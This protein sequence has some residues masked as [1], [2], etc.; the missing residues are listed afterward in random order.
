MQTH[1][2]LS[3]HT[4]LTIRSVSNPKLTDLN[5]WL[6]LM[7]EQIS[8]HGLQSLG[9][10]G[11]SFSGFGGYTAVHCL[12]ESHISIHT[13]PE[14]GLCTCDVFLSNFEKDND[15]VVREITG[16][17]LSYFESGSYDL[18]EIKR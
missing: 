5:A 18:N 15:Q 6:K 11:H 14:F 13:W 9:H 7:E 1:Y 4:L 12:T 10:I 2:Q 8:R 16:S 17:I 3:L